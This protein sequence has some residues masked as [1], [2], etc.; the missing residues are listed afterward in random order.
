MER[1]FPIHR[2]LVGPGFQASLAEVQRSLPLTV[3]EFPS[4]T[5]CFDWTIPRGFKVNEGYVEAED[6]SRPIDFARCSYHVWNYSQPFDGELDRE[7]LV[8][9]LTTRP[10]LPD[11][12]P[13][14]VTYYR[15]KWGLAASQCQVDALPPGRYHVHIDTELFDDALRI[16][17]YYLPGKTDDEIL[18]TSY[19]CHPRG[20]NDNQS[21]VVMAVELFKLLAQLPSHYYSYRLVIW[22]EN[23]GAITYLAS[24]PERVGRTLGGYVVTC[25]GDPGPLHY[26]R[27]YFGNSMF[28]RAALHA[29]RH[30]GKP[31]KV[32]DFSFS[33]G[34][35]ETCLSGPGIRL[36]FG[37]LM[38]T[39]YA[40]FPEYHSSLD[41]LSFVRP[42]YLLDSLE[43]Y[44]KII[45]VIERNRIYKPSYQSLPFLTRHD[46]YPFWG[47]A[48]EG[49][50]GARAAEAYYHL[51][52]FT[53][54]ERDLLA[55]ADLVDENIELFDRPVAEFCKAGLL[56]ERC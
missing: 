6:G 45:G 27:T 1:L 10:D 51:M 37:S 53:D 8:K 50:L 41:D 43:L 33:Q 48:G 18:I 42:E 12:V 23:I 3:H 19:L 5:R 29:L 56:T 30:S 22:P 36:P 35:D 38:R 46:I 7:E 16:G 14:C 49:K 20:A 55:I 28:D 39:P 31:F 54:G 15:P 47:G 40:R 4:G 44:C 21:G 32:I 13:L 17:E 26:K 52:G 24:F 11:G 2:S 9:H 25:V 34:S